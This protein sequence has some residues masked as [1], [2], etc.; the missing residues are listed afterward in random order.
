[1]VYSPHSCRGDS[2]PCYQC[3]ICKKRLLQRFKLIKH[4]NWSDCRNGLTQQLKASDLRREN[5][6]G[7]QE[8][9]HSEI[10]EYLD[11]E[12]DPYPFKCDLCPFVIDKQFNL[13]K[14]KLNI[15][16][17]SC[18]FC[19][20][21]RSN[22]KAIKNHINKSHR[23][24]LAEIDKLYDAIDKSDLDL[25]TKK[26]SFVMIYEMRNAAGIVAKASPDPSSNQNNSTPDADPSKLFCVCGSRYSTVIKVILNLFLVLTFI[27]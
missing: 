11:L 24:E 7:S 15:H 1:M 17:L 2:C 14:H 5:R 8:P 25:A 23:R 21:V 18:G 6:S 22:N 26:T 9:T 10:G 4:Q 20:L 27:F 16:H 12:S 19:G 13:T 3:S